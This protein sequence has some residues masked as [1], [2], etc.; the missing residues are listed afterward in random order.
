M[1]GSLVEDVC[2]GAQE[3]LYKD[4]GLSLPK[5]LKTVKA[6]L[7]ATKLFGKDAIK[8]PDYPERRSAAKD[9]L[10]LMGLIIP[11]KVEVGGSLNVRHS[12]QELTDA[13]L[14]AIAASGS[15]G[16]PEKAGGSQESA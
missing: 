8:H 9:L 10:A 4:L 7:R 12:V 13:E 6:S 11:T 3:I 1:S 2:K 16:T 15:P 14:A 5:L